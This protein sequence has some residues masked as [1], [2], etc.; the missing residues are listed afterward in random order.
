MENNFNEQAFNWKNEQNRW[1]INNIFKMHEINFLNSWKK[2]NEVRHS[3]T[4]NIW[5]GKKPDAPIFN[6]PIE[7]NLNDLVVNLHFFQLLMLKIIS[8]SEKETI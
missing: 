5:N 1:K 3:K 7:F 4:L 2:T 6:Y 8:M